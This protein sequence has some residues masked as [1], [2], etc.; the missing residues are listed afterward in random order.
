[1]F[2]INKLTVGPIV[3]HV[4]INNARVWGRAIY[5]ELSNG[6]PRRAFGIVRIKKEGGGYKS[7]QF[8]KMNP[9][10]D[11]SGIAVFQGLEPDT[12]YTYQIG[13]FFF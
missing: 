12:T 13:W 5:Q 1:M 9:N 6:K 8:F 4:D 11:M 7:P 3:G 10:F 2:E